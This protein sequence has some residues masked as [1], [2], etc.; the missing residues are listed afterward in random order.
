MCFHLAHGIEHDPDNDQQARAAEK[1][2]CDHRH[3]ESLAQK[4]WQ[5]RYQ[6]QKDRAGK[7]ESCHGE[8]E[9]IRSRFPGPYAGMETTVFLL[10]VPY[11]ERLNM[12]ANHKNAEEDKQTHESDI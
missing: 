7:R 11:F 1:L 12:V 10:S 8:F 4:A 5:H 3:V 9:K 2:R 6:R